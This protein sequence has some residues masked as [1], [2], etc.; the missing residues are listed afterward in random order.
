MTTVRM[1]ECELGKYGKIWYLCEYKYKKD[2]C[3]SW[4]WQI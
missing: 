2:I 4:I 1:C 3:T